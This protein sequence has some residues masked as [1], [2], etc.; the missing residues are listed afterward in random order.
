MERFF[1]KVKEKG[2][3]LFLGCQVIV[4][5]LMIPWIT[6]AVLVWLFPNFS[7]GL[8]ER[9]VCPG[10]SS[11][12]V[13]G[14]KGWLIA[15][16]EDDASLEFPQFT[17]VNSQGTVVLRGDFFD[18]SFT[19]NRIAGVVLLFY[20]ALTIVFVLISKIA[21]GYINLNEKIPKKKRCPNCR[22]LWTGVK[23]RDVLIDR[24]QMG[25]EHGNLENL[26]RSM[27]WY[28]KFKIYYKCKHCGYEWTDI[29]TRKQ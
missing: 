16:L 28:E 10:N 13:Q 6:T 27:I 7:Y 24:F 1:D 9:W 3:D 2:S 14:T 23:I 15:V 25:E 22:Y 21:R 4:Y 20:L 11:I 29:T 17:C 5:A 12:Q 8:V 19:Y 26:E 18:N